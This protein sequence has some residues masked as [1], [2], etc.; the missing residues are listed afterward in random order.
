VLFFT[1]HLPLTF[2]SLLFNM[3]L[4]PPL[5]TPL[6]FSRIPPRYP[7]TYDPWLKDFS[8]R[9]VRS[10]PSDFLFLAQWVSK[11]FPRPC[12]AKLK[13][14]FYDSMR[15]YTRPLSTAAI[16]S[17]FTSLEVHPARR[18]E[19]EP[20]TPR[21]LGFSPPQIYPS[22][23]PFFS[24]RHPPPAQWPRRASVHPLSLSL[25]SQREHV[26]ILF[27]FRVDLIPFLT[28]PRLRGIGTF[29]IETFRTRFLCCPRRR[30]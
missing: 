25:H 18:H 2:S 20:L 23:V 26:G 8:V 6:I 28:H 29:S 12:S 22:S 21:C 27:F 7:S 24:C 5:S 13:P 14:G 4:A 16:P 30:P 3:P 15:D 19:L 17:T 11:V 10:S 9:H 1:S